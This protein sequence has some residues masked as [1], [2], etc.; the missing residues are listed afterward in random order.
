M[1]KVV[2]KSIIKGL[3]TKD[4]MEITGLKK[5]VIEEKRCLLKRL[6]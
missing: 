2:E 4:I 3:T 6:K 1:D 5:E